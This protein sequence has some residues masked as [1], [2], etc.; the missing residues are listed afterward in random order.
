MAPEISFLMWPGH[1]HTCRGTL[2]KGPNV[3]ALRFPTCT[4]ELEWLS[5]VG[6]IQ[7]RAVEP[8]VGATPETPPHLTPPS[9]APCFLGPALSSLCVPGLSGAAQRH[10]L[11]VK[12]FFFFLNIFN[13]FVIFLNIGI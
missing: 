1:R 11:C 13:V 8:L 9:E 10:R 2:G 7:F 3:S 6:Q 5:C 12:A 4:V